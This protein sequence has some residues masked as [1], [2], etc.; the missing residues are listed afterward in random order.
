MGALE[1]AIE[2]YYDRGINVLCLV[3]SIWLQPRPMGETDET[4]HRRGQLLELMRSSQVVLPMPD[5]GKSHL[6]PLVS[7]VLLDCDVNTV[8]VTN[9][10]NLVGSAI[11]ACKSRAAQDAM[12]IWCGEFVSSFSFKPAASP[13][14]APHALQFVPNPSPP[15][16]SFAAITAL[17]SHFLALGDATSAA[18]AE[19]RA[20]AELDSLLS[21]VELPAVAVYRTELLEGLAAR[22]D[23]VGLELPSGGAGASP[24]VKLDEL[25]PSRRFIDAKIAWD[26]V[27]KIIFFAKGQGG[28]GANGVANSHP[29]D[30][31]DAVLPSG[32]TGELAT[33][34]RRQLQHH[35]PRGYAGG[36]AAEHVMARALRV[37]D[38][39]FAAAATNLADFRAAERAKWKA[40]LRKGL[41]FTDGS[42][43][44][45]HDFSGHGAEMTVRVKW[46][47]HRTDGREQAVSV[48]LFASKFSKLMEVYTWSTRQD[49]AAGHGGVMPG[50]GGTPAGGMFPPLFLARLFAMVLRYETLSATKSAYQAAIPDALFSLL[51]REMGVQHECYASPLNHWCPS[52]CSLFPDTDRFFGSKGPFQEWAPEAGVHECNPPF[53]NASV[54]ACFQRL[55]ALLSA[56]P[57]GTPLSFVVVT[58][59][60]D[61]TSRE[62]AAAMAAIAPFCTR[63]VECDI[64]EHVYRMGLQHRPQYERDGKDTLR[65][66]RP[67][68]RSWIAFLQNEA[69]AEAHRVTDALVA[70]AR[71]CFDW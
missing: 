57:P 68:K 8:L 7:Y 66:W 51:Q 38:E 12:R 52:Y 55:S 44:L 3:P 54:C 48:E 32:I 61:D 30:A 5:E 22:I 70:E 16:S 64:N 35:Y 39:H 28:G 24:H 6:P 25:D 10:K 40:K 27:N 60:M 13:A 18:E 36:A 15:P 42:L 1:A 2:T 4:A 29:P 62:M 71:N 23:H 49:A 46:A 41:V 21:G 59:V 33:F 53:N 69:G 50:G 11:A 26:V 19:A 20:D 63:R 31:M 45:S 14:L 17:R 58:P 34:V 56:A 43:G 37:L 47:P 9:D 67:E 65:H